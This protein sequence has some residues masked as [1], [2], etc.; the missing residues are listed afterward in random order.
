ME[1]SHTIGNVK[2]NL[3]YY[4]Q[5]DIY[6]DG[7]IEQWLLDTVKEN[8]DI[9]YTDIISENASWPVLYHL[10]SGREA[11]LSWYPFDKEDSV[12]EIGA[13]C[14]AVTGTLLHTCKNVTSL[15]L[16]L[17]RSEI[18]AYRHRDAKNLEI[19]V[20]NFQNYA[21]NTNDKFSVITL[22]GVLEYAALY[23]QNKK[24]FVELLKSAEDMLEPNGAILIAIENRLGLKYF[25]GCRED[26]LGTFFS[27]IENYKNEKS[28]KT[29]SKN[30]IVKVC[31]EA[32]LNHCKFYYPYP[33]YKFP[34]CIY[35][36]E[37][38]PKKGELV[39]NIRNFD[40]DR[41]V[42]FDETKA[43][44]GIIS[45]GLFPEFSN[46]FFIEARRKYE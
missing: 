18:N 22:I 20:S 21:S 27:G 34:T 42:L 45:A 4:T 8:G 19:I 36:D 6:S 46:S 40:A 33:D 13:G 26:H 25:A 3:Q 23:I 37:W 1:K 12:L 10:S 32:G 16:S 15:D 17:R 24:P 9:D 7:D 29:F 31:Q 39:N 14:G 38:L 30:E 11:I 44:D 35:S 5:K 28:V 2:L 41:I 43:F